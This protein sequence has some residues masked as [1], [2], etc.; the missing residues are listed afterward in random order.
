LRCGISTVRGVWLAPLQRRFQQA[1]VCRLLLEIYNCCHCIRMRRNAS[2]GKTAEVCI[3]ARAHRKDTLRVMELCPWY[4]LLDVAP[5]SA[6][7]PL[8]NSGTQPHCCVASLPH[9]V[10]VNRLFEGIV[11]HN[12][13]KRNDEKDM[14]PESA[15]P[16][17]KRHP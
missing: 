7:W 11:L 4:E 3:R 17:R 12:R 15:N 16:V 13:Y 14:R 1:T 10:T 5:F 8:R 9:D 2:P 6:A